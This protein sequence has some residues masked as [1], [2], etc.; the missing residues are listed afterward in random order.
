MHDAK[1]F[2]E[3]TVIFAEQLWSLLTVSNQH[4]KNYVKEYILAWHYFLN[5]GI[6][7]SLQAIS[8][9]YR[10]KT[11]TD[12]KRSLLV[13]VSQWATPERVSTPFLWLSPGLCMCWD[14][15]SSTE[16]NFSQNKQKIKCIV[17]GRWDDAGHCQKPKAGSIQAWENHGSKN[18]VWVRNPFFVLFCFIC[19]TF[20]SVCRPVFFSVSHPHD[21]KWSLITPNSK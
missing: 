10:L 17:D 6:D 5:I 20:Y 8:W 1:Q 16:T 9:K 2:P 18:G 15:D 3:Q 21:R 12:S 7:A 11:K 13:A 14:I 19:D 4:L